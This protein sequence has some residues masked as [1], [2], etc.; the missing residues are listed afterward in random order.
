MSNITKIHCDKPTIDDHYIYDEKMK[1]RIP[2]QLYGI[3]SYFP[4]RAL[5]LDEMPNCDQIE[6]I[7][8]SPDAETWYPYFESYSINEDQ[9]VDS[10]G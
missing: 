3:F 7:F 5:T 8:L 4:T 9:L 10:G 6:H 1:L 2:L